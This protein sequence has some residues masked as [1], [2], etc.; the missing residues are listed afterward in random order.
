MPFNFQSALY[1]SSVKKLWPNITRVEEHACTILIL[2]SPLANKR[3]KTIPGISL[4]HFFLLERKCTY[5]RKLLSLLRRSL[6]S[7]A[8]AS[9]HVRALCSAANVAAARML[10]AVTSHFSQ[11]Q[12]RSSCLPAASISAFTSFCCCPRWPARGALLA[13]PMR[14]DGEKPLFT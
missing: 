3:I 10:R 2:L 4:L 11:A 5:T 6:A 1:R 13:S 8:E 9:I 12:G 7:A 14:I